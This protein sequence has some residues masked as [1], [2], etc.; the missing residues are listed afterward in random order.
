MESAGHTSSGSEQ[1]RR[2]SRV[3]LSVP[4]VISG[5]DFEVEGETIDVNRHGAKIRTSY[6]LS[7]GMEVRVTIASTGQSRP[8]RVVL[9]EVGE[10]GIELE[11]PENF[12]GVYSPPSD[13]QEKDGLPENCFPKTLSPDD[14]GV[15]DET[16]AP[17]SQ[18]ATAMLPPIEIPSEGIEVIVSGLNGIHMPFQEQTVLIPV[19]NDSARIAIK[20]MVDTG[21]RLRLMITSRN[22]TVTARVVGITAR[23]HED[24]W[25][26][27]V[28]FSGDVH[29]VGPEK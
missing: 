27:W 4:I 26:T 22:R 24:K 6:R 1:K 11:T 17:G 23:K 28:E 19:S 20:Q 10:F 29:L 13:W 21:A 18:T 8:A 2:S 5:P 9:L 14:V 16:P 3:L 12:W 25:I 15:S 7:L